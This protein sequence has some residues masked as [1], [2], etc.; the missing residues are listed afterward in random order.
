MILSFPFL[1]LITSGPR[2]TAR[3]AAFLFLSSVLFCSTAAADGQAVSAA[4]GPGTSRPNIVEPAQTTADSEDL[5]YVIAPDDLLEVYVV[6]VPEF[7]REYRVGPDGNITLPMVSEPIEAAGL[8][9]D[10]LSSVIAAKLRSAGLVTHASVMVNVKSSRV[11]S[12]AITGAVNNPQIYSIFGK[13]TL[14]DVLTQAGGLANNASDTTVIIRGETAMRALG[15][16]DNSGGK[17]ATAPPTTIKV[18]LQKLFEGGDPR[19]DIPIFPG[20]TVTVLRAG[21]VYVVGAVNRAGGYTLAGSWQNMTVL[22]AIALAGNVTSTALRKKSVII[23]KDPAA[24]GGH[25][26]IRVNLKKILAG[27]APDQRL[28]AND[29]L[30]VPDSTGKKAFRRGVESALGIGTG[31]LIYRAPL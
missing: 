26:Q 24:P 27:K 15:F 17:H 14:L 21:I 13:T 2:N 16:Q 9:P 5:E 19:S 22:K 23:R 10:Q 20:D 29:I 25:E 3:H 12:V 31:L 30:F 11:H 7:S 1:H 4:K 28:E 18:N 8:T 6:D